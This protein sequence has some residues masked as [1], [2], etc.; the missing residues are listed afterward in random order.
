MDGEGESDGD[1]P[2]LKHA[3][4]AS[5]PEESRVQNLGADSEGDDMVIVGEDVSMPSSSPDS[6][7]IQPMEIDAD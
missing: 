2:P 4:C 6:T 5:I 7:D 1:C 3:K